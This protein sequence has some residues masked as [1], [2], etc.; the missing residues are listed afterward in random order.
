V[1]SPIGARR[2]RSTS[3]GLLFE[4]SMPRTCEDL[5]QARE[6]K[7]P[8]AGRS[9][10]SRASLRRLAASMR[11][12]G[13]YLAC[14]PFSSPIFLSSLPESRTTA[15]RG[16]ENRAKRRARARGR[17]RRLDERIVDVN[18]MMYTRRKLKL[19]SDRANCR[20][21]RTLT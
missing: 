7:S 13:I 17:E 11:R 4:E 21:A 19:E 1:A 15:S 20:H 5:P 18:M 3:R 6:E 14:S 16:H 8:R 10:R 2:A 12:D 9:D